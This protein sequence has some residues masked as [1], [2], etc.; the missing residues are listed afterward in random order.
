[1][2]ASLI[3]FHNNK[4]NRFKGSV[5]GLVDWHTCMRS[6]YI[7]D[8]RLIPN[9]AYYSLSEYE[10]F[11]GYKAYSI[12]L[13][14][15]SGIRSK[16]FGESEIQF[17]FNDRFSKK[18]LLHS[19][20]SESI[21]K[22]K[23]HILEHVKQ[24]RSEYIKGKGRLTYGGIADSLLPGNINLAIL[25]TGQLAESMIIHL[26]KKNRNVK[27]IGRNTERLQFLNQKFNISTIDY[28]NFQPSFHS[29]IIANPFLPENL[30]SQLSDSSIV[31]DFRGDDSIKENL[32]PNKIS[33][34]SFQSILNK[35][36]ATKENEE[37]LKSKIISRIQELTEERENEVLHNPNGWED[38]NWMA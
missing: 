33:Y 9:S 21:L 34:F 29:I 27:I 5:E 13:E 10:I 25:G 3:I 4:S 18:N 8:Q 24:I 31:L 30:I 38:I 19:P 6:V 15:V 17:Q 14:I 20:F 11:T 1:M 23:N 32:L 16:L 26:M 28:N 37:F 35:I 12:L 36:Q 7:G 2:W 22:L